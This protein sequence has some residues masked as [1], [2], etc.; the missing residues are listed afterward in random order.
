MQRAH[1]DLQHAQAALAEHRRSPFPQSGQWPSDGLPTINRPRRPRWPGFFLQ[2]QQR[3]RFGQRLSLRL[4]SFSSCRVFLRSVNSRR[5][6]RAAVSSC[7]PRPLLASADL[8]AYSLWAVLGQLLLVQ[9]ASRSRRSLFSPP[10]L[11]IRGSRHHLP[12]SETI[13]QA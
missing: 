5:S 13:T 4:S 3:R 9:R 7:H 8:L 10:V 6:Q 2:H 12:L 11:G 1:I